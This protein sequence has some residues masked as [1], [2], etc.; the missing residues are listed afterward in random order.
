MSKVISKEYMYEKLF[1]IRQLLEDGH[2]KTAHK[3]LNTLLTACAPSS[4][5]LEGKNDS[6]VVKWK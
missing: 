1:K 5:T 3:K 2:Y 4:D 6:K